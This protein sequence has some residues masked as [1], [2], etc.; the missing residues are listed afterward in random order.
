MGIEGRKEGELKGITIHNMGGVEVQLHSFL[1]NILDRG[2]RL[3]ACRSH[4]TAGKN[5]GTH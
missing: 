4:L 2:E 1:T 3:T 5:P